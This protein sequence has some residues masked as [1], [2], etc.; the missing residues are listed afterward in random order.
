VQYFSTAIVGSD[1]FNRFHM[2]SPNDDGLFA[3]K[4]PREGRYLD[5]VLEWKGNVVKRK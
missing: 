1:Q 3:Y 4:K 2:G 5:P